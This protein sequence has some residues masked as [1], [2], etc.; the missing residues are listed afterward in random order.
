MKTYI[1]Y[2]WIRGPVNSTK[3]QCPNYLGALKVK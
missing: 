1:M 3:K 2:V